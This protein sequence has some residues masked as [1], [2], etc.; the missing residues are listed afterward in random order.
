MKKKFCTLTTVAFMMLLLVSLGAINCVRAQGPTRISWG[1]VVEPTVDGEWT[2]PDEWTDGGDITTIGEDVFFT[3]TWLYGADDVMT[4]WLVEFYSDTTD[5]AEDYWEF[6]MDGNADGGSAPQADD[7]KFV[8]TGH[9]DLVWYQGTGTGWDV[10]DLD[11]TEITWAN[12]LSDSPSDS[13]EHYIL[14]FVIG[15]NTGTVLLTIEWNCRLAVYDASNSEAGELAWPEGSDADDPSS[16]GIESYTSE[17]VPEGLS[18]GVMVLLSSA[19]VIGASVVL[20][21]RSKKGQI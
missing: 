11:E 2:S 19:A 8:I 5:D 4:H 17:T 12:S 20:R 13:T 3:S 14:E 16:Y 10:A 15:K 9:T 1:M 18:F 6:C 7:F 21:K